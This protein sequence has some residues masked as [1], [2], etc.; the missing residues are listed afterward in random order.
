[1]IGATVQPIRKRRLLYLRNQCFTSALL[2]SGG[3]SAAEPSWPA[4]SAQCEFDI[5]TCVLSLD[6]LTRI[7]QSLATAMCR[8]SA[9]SGTRLTRARARRIS[10]PINYSLARA[11]LPH[12][13]KPTITSR[14]RRYCDEST[15]TSVFMV[16]AAT[17]YE[18]ET[19]C[20]AKE[21]WRTYCILTLSWGDV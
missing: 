11:S 2:R 19:F 21:L 20:L 9:S 5:K 13:S 18:I 15:S 3:V 16:G 8:D 17:L 12:Q 4:P 1:M 7:R 14:Q 10:T 6:R